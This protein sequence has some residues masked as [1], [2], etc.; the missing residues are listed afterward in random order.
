MVLANP[1]PLALLRGE[2]GLGGDWGWWVGEEGSRGGEADRD[3][4]AVSDMASAYSTS[5]RLPPESGAFLR[6]E[7]DS[8]TFLSFRLSTSSEEGWLVVVVV[9]LQIG[10]L[11]TNLKIVSKI[12]FK[13]I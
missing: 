9:D 12:Y 10:R 13:N 2:A 11:E 1:R 3:E 4:S 5:D 8:G 7:G 6:V